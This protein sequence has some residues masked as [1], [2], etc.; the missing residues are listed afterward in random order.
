MLKKILLGLG[1]L[2]LILCIAMLYMTGPSGEITNYESYPVGDNS[3]I[4][5]SL[6]DT[7]P[8]NGVKVTFFGVSTLLFDDG[9]TQLLL[10]GFFSRPSL[11]QTFFT[12]IE[13][14][15]SLID[16]IVATYQMDRVKGIFVTHSHYDHALDVAY[17]TRKTHA[18]LYGSQST[19][20]IARGGQVQEN[21]LALFQ[22]NLDVPCG[23]FTV[24]VIPSKHSPGNA[25]NDDGKEIGS[26]L[27]QPAKFKA[28]SEG[29]SFDFLITHH[30]KSIYI[31]PSPNFIEGALKDLSADVVFIGIATIG[32]Q[33]E[34]WQNDFYQQTIGTLKPSKVIPIH[35]DNF[36]KPIS[37]KLVMLPRI[38]N[39]T[40]KDFDFFRAKTKAE[41]IDFKI[42]QG[43][44]SIVLFNE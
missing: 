32:K 40:E 33:P 36:W 11:I 8:Q 20:N 14:D 23:A 30:G 24:R 25:L 28:Y 12:K 34:K 21:Q 9:E 18:T 44:K 1:V 29:G 37:D 41:G 3:R 26:P 39:N 6:A 16:Q 43:T 38:L 13:S 19:L 31:K 7:T 27:P 4:R 22:P 42:L 35:W 15:T 10:D 5:E 17:T 2:V